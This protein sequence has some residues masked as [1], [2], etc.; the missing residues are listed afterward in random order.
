MCEFLAWG[1]VA[2]VLFLVWDA[3]SAEDWDDVPQPIRTVAY[4]QMT[5]YWSGYYE[6]G[7]TYSLGRGLVADTL[8][9]IVMSESWFEHRGLYINADGSRDIGLAGAS[10]FARARLR[11]LFARGMVD[12]GPEDADYENP[13]VATRFVA[14]WMSI[15][16][17]EANGDLDTAI[18]AYNRGIADANDG[19]GFDYLTAVQRR[20]TTFI[21]NRGAPPAWSHL[22][23]RG[24]D[25]ERQAWPWV[26][27]P[28]IV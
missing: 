27:R 4:R 24:R 1:G 15:L 19:A 14:I 17:D 11:Q 5:A 26:A 16:L 25:L 9:A 7:A 2:F 22:W 13:W 21:R 18:G 28:P 8:A 6:V 3:M 23:Q 20:L 12:A 10:D